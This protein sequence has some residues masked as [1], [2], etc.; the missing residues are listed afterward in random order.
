MTLRHILLLLIFFTFIFSC[1]EVDPNKQIDE[2]KIE[3]NTYVSQD[4][5]W[6][7]EIPKGWEIVTMEETKSYEK[8]GLDAIEDMIGEDIDVSNLKNLVSFKKDMF[9]LFQSDSEAFEIEY[10]DEWEESNIALKDFLLETYIDQGIKATASDIS[11]ESI[12]GLEFMRYEFTLYSPDDKV[13]LNQLIYT[14]LIN[15]YDFGVNINYNNEE[16]KNEML[17]VFRNSKFRKTKQKN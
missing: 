7:M 3:N 17:R 15:G 9:N 6:E 4:I 16:D 12:D 5:G 13:I 1:K 2:G 11:T 8:K 14:R 10:E